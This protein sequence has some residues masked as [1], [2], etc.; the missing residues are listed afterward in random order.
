MPDWTDDRIEL[1][2]SLWLEGATSTVISER[3]GISRSAA[4]GKIRRLGMQ[5]SVLAQQAE[6]AGGGDDDIPAPRAADPVTASPA[7]D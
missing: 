4:L 6:D 2:K 1:L 5:R 7:P 3:L